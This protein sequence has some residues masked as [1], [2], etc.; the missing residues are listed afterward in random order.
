MNG[1]L[2][3]ILLFYARSIAARTVSFNSSG[4]G[5]VG[6]S[7]QR[8]GRQK[9]GDGLDSGGFMTH[10]DAV[11]CLGAGRH[12]PADGLPL[13]IDPW[14][15]LGELGD[16]EDQVVAVVEVHDVERLDRIKSGNDGGQLHD[17]TAS[18]DDRPVCKLHV[19]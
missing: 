17:E 16:A 3:I 14:L 4:P 9:Q 1:G 15:M 19:H 8:E 13:P 7:K 18:N 12:R 10:R 6:K 2:N 11:G 5:C